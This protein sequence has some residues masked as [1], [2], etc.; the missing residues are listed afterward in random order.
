MLKKAVALLCAGVMVWLD[1][2]TKILAVRHL[3]EAPFVLWDGVF[4]LTYVENRGAAWGLGQGGRWIFVA[5]TAL[6]IAALLYL[7]L[8][9]RLDGQKWLLVACV[10]IGA[11]GVGNLIDRVRDGFVVDFFYFSL[12]DFPVFNVADCFVVIG[13][14]LMAFCVLFV[15]KEP[16]VKTAKEGADGASDADS[17]AADGG[18]EDR[19]LAAGSALGDTGDGAEVVGTGTGDAAGEAAE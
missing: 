9:G 18:A 16:F 8:S 10:L 1:Q 17:P 13:S 6:L 2:W 3:K 14:F 7:L 15:Y 12:I 4:E 11:G 19:P 5:I